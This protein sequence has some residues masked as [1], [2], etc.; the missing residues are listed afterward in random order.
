MSNSPHRQY[1]VQILTQKVVFHP[2]R[3]LTTYFNNFSIWS[4]GLQVTDFQ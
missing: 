4:S 1:Q 3:I 2:L